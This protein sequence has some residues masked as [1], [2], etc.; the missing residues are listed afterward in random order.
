MLTLQKAQSWDVSKYIPDSETLNKREVSGTCS[1]SFSLSSEL[2]H[3]QQMHTEEKQ[4]KCTECLKS[5]IKLSFLQRHQRTHTGENPYHCTECLKSFNQLSSLQT[6]QRTHTGEKPYDCSECGSSFIDSSK[7]RRHQRTHTGEKPY[8]CTECVKSFSQL[9]SLQKHQRT[10]T[11]EKPY[12]CS[13]CGS[14]FIDSSKLRNHQRTHT[15]EKPFKCTECVKRFSRSAHLKRHQG[16]HTGEKPYHCSECGNS[17]RDSSTLRNHQRLHTGEKP[18]KCSECVKSFTRLLDLKH[19]Q[20]THT[21]ERPFKCGECVKSF[22]Q[23]P[24]LI[25]HQKAHTMEKPFKCSECWMCF[26]FLS[27]LKR[28]QKT[29]TGEKPFNCSECGKSFSQLAHLKEHQRTHTGEKPYHCN[30]CVKRFNRLAHLKQHQKT[31]TQAKNI[32]VQWV[33]VGSCTVKEEKVVETRMQ[34]CPRK[35]KATCD[36]GVQ[37]GNKR[38]C[39]KGARGSVFDTMD[40]FQGLSFDDEMVAA[41]LQTPSILNN[42][43]AAPMGS[44]KE[45][46]DKLSTLKRDLIKTVMHGT[47]MTEYL[48]ANIAPNGLLVSNIPRIFLQDLAFRKDWAQIAWKCTRDWLVL[49]IN[50]SRRLADTITIQ[51]NSLEGTLRTTVTLAAFK[52]RLAEINTELNETKVFLTNQKIT[53]LQKDITRF[54]RE[55]VYPYTLEDFEI[56]GQS[57]SSDDS[58]SSYKK[59]RKISNSSSSD[60]WNKPS[61]STQRDSGLRPKSIFTPPPTTIP[62]EVLAFEKAVLTDLATIHP[63]RPFINIPTIERKALRTLDE[64]TSIVIKQADKGGAIVI[65]NTVDY[66]HE[67]LRLL[68]DDTYYAKITRDPTPRLQSQIKSMILEATNNAWIS[69]KEAAFLDTLHPKV[70][71]FYCLPKIHKDTSPPPGRPIVSG[72][73]SLLEPLSVFC[74]HFLQP[75]VKK[76]STYLQDTKDVLNLIDLINETVYVH[77]LITLD[78]EAL[79]TNIPQD[80]TLQ[81]VETTLLENSENLTSP[82][83]FI[84]Q[85]ANLAMTENFFQFENDFYHQIR[86]TCMGSTFA[87]SLA[88]LYMY[89]FEKQ[90]I[91]PST[92][93]FF[94]N[95]KLWRR[96]I[97]DIL[98]VW[99][100]SLE[101]ASTFTDW[102]NTLNPFL[103]FSSTMST[104]EI[105]FLDLLITI[106]N[107]KLSTSTYHKPTDRNSLLT[108]D[109]HHPKSLRN[110]LPFGQFLRLRR[111]CSSTNVYKTQ[112]DDL[113][114]KLTARNYPPDVVNRARKRARNNNRE[115]LL[116]SNTRD[117]RPFLIQILDETVYTDMSPRKPAQDV[118]RVRQLVSG[119][120]A[121]QYGN[122]GQHHCP[123]SGQP[124]REEN[125]VA[126][127]I[128]G[129]TAVPTGLPDLSG[130]F[131][132]GEMLLERGRECENNASATSTMLA[133]QETQSWDV[134]KYIPDPKTLTKREKSYACSESFSL[135]SVLK[136]HQQT[137]SSEKPFKCS[138]FVKRYN[139]S[140]LLKEYQRTHTMEKRF[141]CTECLKCFSWLSELQRHQRIHTGEKP[142]KCSECVKSFSRLSHL[143][144]HQRTHTGEKPYICS[145]CGSSFRHSSTLK[146]HQRTHTGEKPFK[147]TECA[148]CFTQ[149]SH[150]QSH[151]Q[152]HS[153][154]KPYHCN[155]CGSRFRDFSKLRI[156]Q[157]THTGDKPYH[158]NDCGHSYSDSSTLRL[159]QQT[160]T[161]EKLFKCNECGT[162]FTYLSALKYHQ[163]IH[164][165]E[166]PY[167][168]SECE[169]S[170]RDCSALRIHHR[171]H[172]GE[173]PFKCAECLKSFSQ[174]AHLQIHQRTHTGEKPYN[175]SECRSSFRDSYALRIHHRTHTGEKPFKCAEC[176]KSFS[177]LA[178]LQIHQRTH[179]GEKPYS[180]SKCRSSFRDSSTLRIHYR[181]H[182][183]EKPFKC[184]ECVKSFRK[185]G[186]LQSHQ[187]I[188]TGE[189]PFMCI[190]WNV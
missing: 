179:T 101:T 115:A 120:A 57:R 169:S 160:H 162:S 189:K 9:S 20:T 174:L 97:D 106:Q 118:L 61:D 76:S 95:I 149:L 6:H 126:L 145:E 53:K 89:N 5:F 99:H 59:S 177:Q 172:T 73:G 82:V 188:H 79:Y 159:H 93:P 1:K 13:E 22:S 94:A 67:C 186:H 44:L 88:C 146:N 83:S 111:N 33:G 55:K 143:Q 166:K 41:I 122:T 133:L 168:C 74:D 24:L 108:Y 142:F 25:K 26:I 90:F 42:D 87:P 86:G 167:N 15:G 84:M 32:Q 121:A 60:G 104:N 178:H 92:N 127:P 147:C 132:D 100:G 62:C 151:Q 157:R 131:L 105:S 136:R 130:A 116:A 64:D 51:I 81:V 77:G 184:S 119:T 140:A 2:R 80:A 163:R 11:G 98:V 113:Q 66:R 175:C 50:T 75:L 56:D 150:L 109:S 165:G 187:R 52:T 190:E 117:R 78:V 156:H 43:G 7:L 69:P 185:L 72:I 158:C 29:H 47:I 173:K 70:P 139:Q 134:D 31:H 135:S 141:R 21:G 125:V 176:V 37:E 110:N 181:T 148:K 91:L 10:H 14:S 114:T 19:H 48:R 102:V 36:E 164:T 129:R 68:S 85:C 170:F 153:G 180:C 8:H 38:K 144:T 23:L 65:M 183:G 103:K 45:D 128:R 71:Y 30:E 49:I 137:H 3:P 161:G 34:K 124:L 155:E 96:Y 54:S 182:T 28:H 171:T 35:S 112:A 17:F 40:T 46:W 16:T 63:K 154:E 27:N 123:A 138:E 39:K 152:T 58:Q 12:D 18:F 107:G 4:F